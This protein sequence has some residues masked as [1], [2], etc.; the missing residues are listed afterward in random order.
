MPLGSGGGCALAG[1]AVT[2]PCARRACVPVGL[3][4]RTVVLQGDLGSPSLLKL[5]SVSQTICSHEIGDSNLVSMRPRSAISW[6]VREAANHSVHCC[7]FRRAQIV[8]H[9][10]VTIFRG[11]GAKTMV[12]P[13]I[14]GPCPAAICKLQRKQALW[15]LGVVCIAASGC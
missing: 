3:R 4:S 9:L 6:S 15:H 1:L 13:C 8:T 11:E 2:P 5:P 7:K 12:L 10:L 14:P